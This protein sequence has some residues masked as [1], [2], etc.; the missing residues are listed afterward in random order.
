MASTMVTVGGTESEET[1]PER[2]VGS[3]GVI[4]VVGG[5]VA[6]LLLGVLFTGPGPGDEA[7][8][9]ETAVGVPAAS[10]TTNPPLTTTTTIEVVP[11]RLAT[12]V[13]GML[14]VLVTER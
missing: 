1:L 6:G 13:P 14:D 12:M 7:A 10:P 11:S 2:D 4:L 5:L 3:R 9:P 8:P